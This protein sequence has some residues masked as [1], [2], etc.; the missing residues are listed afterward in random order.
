[1]KLDRL[2]G[3]LT[4]LLRHDRVTAPYLAEKF[5]VSRRTIG[6]D[7]DALCRAGIPVVTLQ[8]GGGGISLA[9]GFKLDKS[10]LSANELS[11]IIAGI[12]G[13]G[14]VSDS[15]DIER[16]LEKLTPG[17]DAMISLHEPIIIDLASH[18]GDSLAPKVELLKQAI[19]D[20]RVVEFDYFYE[21]GMSKRSVEP[22]YVIFQWTDWYAFGFCRERQD[23]RM[24]KLKRLWGLTITGETFPKREVPPEKRDWGAWQV[25]DSK[26][27]AIFKP[28]VRFRLIETYGPD[29]F[30]ESEGGLLLEIGYTRRDYLI[31][32]L[33]SF[34]DTVKVLEPADIADDIYRIAK[35]IIDVYE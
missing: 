18:Y 8:G 6:R 2:L 3:I 19:C 4:T 12:K 34:G 15:A 16:V 35:N 26:L 7:I 10:I 17:G 30:S 23:W 28:S 5:E 13:I 1:M 20:K 21:K 27:V 29:S 14:S 22:Y 25:D 11:A 31:G 9:E 33:L 32:W 24:F